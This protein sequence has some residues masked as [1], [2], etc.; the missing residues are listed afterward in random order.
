MGVK[1]PVANF[2]V[3]K[4]SLNSDEDMCR[5]VPCDMCFTEMRDKR[6]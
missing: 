4:S 3:T 5:Y 2:R 1:F 6:I